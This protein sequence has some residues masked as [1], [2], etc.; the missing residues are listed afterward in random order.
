MPTKKKSSIVP[1]L[2]D[3][4]MYAGGTGAVPGKRS[5]GLTLPGIGSLSID[6]ISSERGVHLGYSLHG[7]YLLPGGLHQTIHKDGY[8]GPFIGVYRADLFRTPSSAVVAARNALAS[9]TVENPSRAKR[10]SA[11]KRTTR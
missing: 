6:P 10:G 7:T 9:R 3:W 11:A 8:I 5:Y 1:S 4:D 2:S